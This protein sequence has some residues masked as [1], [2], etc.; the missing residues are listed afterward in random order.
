M[1][2]KWKAWKHE[3]SI[4]YWY[5][6]TDKNNHGEIVV[7]SCGKTQKEMKR[8]AKH[9]AKSLN[10]EESHANSKRQEAAIHSD[11][12]TPDNG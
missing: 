12:D 3:E 11:G 9:I 5:V 8:I 7:Y 10:Q 1:I 6:D 2:T 4:G